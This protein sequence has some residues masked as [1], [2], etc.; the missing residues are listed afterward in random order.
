M[1]I[2]ASA[3]FLVLTITPYILHSEPS[4]HEQVAINMTS[5]MYQNVLF[6]VSAQLVN[7][8]IFGV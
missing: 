6:Q 5:S 1:Y 7:S 2:Y 8:R 4:T 3:R